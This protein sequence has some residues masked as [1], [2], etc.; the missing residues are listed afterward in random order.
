MAA[1]P[2]SVFRNGYAET[3][4]AKVSLMQEIPGRSDVCAKEW[5]ARDVTPPST[6]ESYS[7]NAR[8]YSEITW[9]RIINF[10]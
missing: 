6:A 10:R 5:K 3:V 9:V 4:V 2:G 1:G 8:S 7:E